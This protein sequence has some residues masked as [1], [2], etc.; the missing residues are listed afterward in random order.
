M[1]GWFISFEGLDGVGKISVLIV[2]W[3]GLVN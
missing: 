3:M 1:S 2:I